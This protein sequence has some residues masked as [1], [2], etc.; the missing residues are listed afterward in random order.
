MPRETQAECHLRVLSQQ[1]LTPSK[2]AKNSEL[3][4]SWMFIPRSL[5]ACAV[6]SSVNARRSSA[7]SVLF[8]TWYKRPT[9]ERVL[10]AVA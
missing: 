10:V 6:A 4:G 7:L 5:G 8:R 9:V 1:L 3:S 2:L